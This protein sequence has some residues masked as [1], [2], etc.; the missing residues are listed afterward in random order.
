MA[1][2][3]SQDERIGGEATVAS[4]TPASHRLLVVDDDR[5]VGDSL[6]MLLQLMG[7][8]V[9]VA[10]DGEA[11]LATVAEFKP[12]LALM[13]I[14]MSGMDGYE[15]ARRIRLRCRKGKTLFLSP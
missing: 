10:Y 13:D 11:A 6:V 4:P 9:R 3:P 5:D 15:T 12:D 8:D 14:G 2:A 7:A 1:A